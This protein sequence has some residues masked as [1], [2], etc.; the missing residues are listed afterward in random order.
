MAV[1]DGGTLEH[2]PYFLGALV[3]M[4]TGLVSVLKGYRWLITEIRSAIAEAL[5]HHQE[6]EST[7]QKAIEDRLGSIEEKIERLEVNV[8][9][10]E[11]KV[12]NLIN[13]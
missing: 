4:T 12:G 5:A 7:W 10:M 1:L 6:V 2:M 9:R 13:G 8:A 3:L 11:E